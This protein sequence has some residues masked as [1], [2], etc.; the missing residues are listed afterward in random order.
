MAP[1]LRNRPAL[2]RSETSRRAKGKG[3]ASLISKSSKSRVSRKPR[4][5][6]VVLRP[7]SPSPAPSQP[8]N[9]RATFLGL[10]AELRLLIYHHVFH[11]ALI[12]VHHHPEANLEDGG[13]RRAWFSWTPCLA[14]NP[15]SPLLCANPKWS[16]LCKDSERCTYNPKLKPNPTSSI[17][18]MWTCKFV[19]QEAQ[20]LLL[21]ETVVSVSSQDLN[22]WV[23]YLSHI[24]PKHLQSLR[25]ITITGPDRFAPQ[26]IGDTME[27][28]RKHF[29]DLEAVAFQGQ[30][31]I[32]LALG[33]N[34]L[35]FPKPVWH[36]WAMQIRMHHF[37]PR[38]AV[39]IEGF[40]WNKPR[41]PWK[42]IQEE[43][44]VHRIYREGKTVGQ[45][46]KD[47]GWSE[48]DVVVEV[49]RG[50]LVEAKRNA[51]WRQWWR[52]ERCRHMY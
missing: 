7:P 14:P 45:E 31:P 43:H 18:I 37:D 12:H 50:P 39:A 46:I 13:W 51:R 38:V 36:L 32:W 25:R 11:S 15:K 48:E 22:P 23:R 52:G 35:H 10:P 33:N 8:K 9:P 4:V 28:V 42:D 34:I 26:I 19:Y 29:P 30:V 41:L 17:A 44:V 5:Q 3:K 24:C 47:R 40:G 20:N 49:Q 16:G 1:T 27:M 6:R 21:R 2:K